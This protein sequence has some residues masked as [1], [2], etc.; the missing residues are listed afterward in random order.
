[1]R[2]PL[3]ALADDGAISALMAAYRRRRGAAEGEGAATAACEFAMARYNVHISL[4]PAKIMQPWGAAEGDE[5]ANIPNSSQPTEP[6]S[7]VIVKL[8][9]LPALLVTRSVIL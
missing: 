8:A 7:T 6:T 2:L 1:M 5:R 9:C 3:V 4:L